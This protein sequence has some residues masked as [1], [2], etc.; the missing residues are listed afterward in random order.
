[1]EV[2]TQHVYFIQAKSGGLIKIGISD[3]P[4]TRL[5]SLQSGSPVPLRIVAIIPGGGRMTEASLHERFAASRMHGEWFA[6]DPDVLAYMATG[7][8]YEPSED[9]T[10]VKERARTKD[11]TRVRLG[12][13]GALTVHAR[14]RTN[15][16][17]ARAAWEA[18]LA[19]EAGITDDLPADEHAKRMD[20]AL[21]ARMMRLAAARWSKP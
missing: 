12:R 6:P 10:L 19:A 2:R 15:T 9:T 16:G 20:H 8:P 1:M 11:P 3:K 7:V 4:E 14:G 13:L 5:R 21:R 18:R 17:P